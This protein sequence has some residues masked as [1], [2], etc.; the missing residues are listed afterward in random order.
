MSLLSMNRQT[1]YPLSE[2]QNYPKKAPLLF[3]HPVLQNSDCKEPVW[4][5]PVPFSARAFSPQIQRHHIKV[6]YYATSLSLANFVGYVVGFL[7]VYTTIRLRC[8]LLAVSLS[9]ESEGHYAFALNL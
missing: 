1:P 6:A 5:L 4:Q 8:L 3:L 2:R 9:F 7:S